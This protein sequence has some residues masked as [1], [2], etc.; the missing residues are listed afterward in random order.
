MAKIRIG[1]TVVNMPDADIAALQKEYFATNEPTVRIIDAAKMDLRQA[2]IGGKNP[3]KKWDPSKP[4]QYERPVTVFDTETGH[5]DEILSV[6]AVK[7]AFNK[8]TREFEYVDSYE[9]YY[10]ATET[11][12]QGYRERLSVHGLT[13]EKI[14]K[15]RRQQ[16]GLRYGKYYDAAEQIKLREFI[17]DSIISGHNV[18][19]ADIAWALGGEV[20]NSVIDTL[21]AME[22]MRGRGGNKL[23]EVFKDIFGKSMGE[24][25]FSHHGA[26]SD[27][28]ATAMILGHLMN[29]NDVT[30]ASLR[31]V[32]KHKGTSIAPLDNPD[33]YGSTGVVWGPY[34]GYLR[35]PNYYISRRNLRMA[36]EFKDPKT[37]DLIPGMHWD[38]EQSEWDAYEDLRGGRRIAHTESM[39][40]WAATFATLTS[41]IE[42]YTRQVAQALRDLSGSAAVDQASARPRQISFLSKFVTSE[43][44]E[45]NQ[46]FI[47]AAQALHIPLADWGSYYKT[48]RDY[49]LKQGKLA[50]T[51][52]EERNLGAW[53]NEL[54]DFNTKQKL[55]NEQWINKRLR[56]AGRAGEALKAGR[57]TQRQYD[58]VT[59]SLGD[60]GDALDEAIKHTDTLEEEHNLGEW[61]NEL[62]DFNKKQGLWNEQWIQKRLRDAGKAEKAYKEGRITKSQY[63]EVTTS[64]GDVGD[65]L[66]EAI[67]HT[68][69]WTSAL[70]KLGQTK[71][72]NPDRLFEAYEKGLGHV[73]GTARGVVPS[74]LLSPINRIA[75]IS[76]T[77]NRYRYAPFKATD[78]I[79]NA[80]PLTF[81]GIGAG[82]GSVIPGVGTLVGG[83]VG[84]GVGGALKLS[85]QVI[86]NVS[87]A[88]INRHYQQMSMGM[89]IV[90]VGIDLVM[91][92]FK[93]LAK[94]TTL[95]TRAFGLLSGQIGNMGALGNPLTTLTGV[96]YSQYQGL[97][98]AEGMLGLG[99][100]TLNSQFE[101]YARQKELL[102]T[103]GQMD[104][105]RVVAA[106]ILGVFNDVY[107][108]GDYG[109]MI[110]TLAKRNL[111]ASDIA[112]V[113]Q[114][115]PHSAQVLEVMKSLGATSL[116][117]LANPT[118]LR[119]IYF[120]NIT[121]TQRKNFR[122]DAYELGAMKGSI[123]N[124]FMRIADMVWNSGGKS[125]GEGIN[126]IIAGVAEGKSFGSAWVELK[127]LFKGNELWQTLKGGISSLWSGEIVPKLL[128]V[129]DK[130]MDLWLTAL[131]HF[132]DVLA[133][134]ADKFMNTIMNL[135]VEGNPIRGYSIGIKQA[136]KHEYSFGIEGHSISEDMG[137]KHIQTAEQALLTIEQA[138]REGRRVRNINTGEYL[139]AE[140]ARAYVE[141]GFKDWHNYQRSFSTTAHNFIGV[142]RQG[143]DA[144]FNELPAIA[145]A[146]KETA[147][148]MATEVTTNI[149]LT[150]ES[151]GR[152]ETRTYTSAGGSMRNGNTLVTVS[153]Y[154]NRSK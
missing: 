89:N 16:K 151:G 136:G 109:S 141:S 123:G 128:G 70:M 44:W 35:D 34:H 8:L 129:V 69:M 79:L 21:I 82:I 91:M 57:I 58:E 112:L 31:Y 54:T 18:E 152:S 95:L 72:F 32:L 81:A 104:Q 106:S 90:G 84:A 40:K 138:E 99:K 55:W 145:E 14:A 149:K 20:K 111:S 85:T 114:L 93:A 23:D 65:A 76:M 110:N 71:V 147:K 56:D 11:K 43:P 125:L 105:K 124:S 51:L 24:M 97:E 132:V 62:T 130:F 113:S 12:T 68:D 41:H 7:L 67:K 48:A 143:K 73:L 100:G 10:Y 64:L 3:F 86:G 121:D 134:F 78:N 154:S 120:N 45:Q 6:G 77:N 144:L 5:N 63:D 36:D 117:Q 127:E 126:R 27:T 139:T 17:G 59:T 83:A 92:P 88:Q 153:S 38:D 42:T 47:D 19:N 150:I 137:G 115:D 96:G 52:E 30:G 94:A 122:V 116:Q 131:D 108:S 102:Y 61:N 87:E 140:Q 33:I 29:R 2:S 148:Q 98:V 37:G 50:N 1:K 146:V 80:S 49:A 39:D 9:R 119:G 133:P 25:G 26:M 53:S 103:T 74:G 15:L 28:M 142:T 4:Y 22:N 60:V 46:R 13:Q 101:N 66:D 135:K 75:D 118:A 107:G